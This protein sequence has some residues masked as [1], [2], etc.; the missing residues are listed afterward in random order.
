MSG[1]RKGNNESMR[2]YELWL[3]RIKYRIENILIKFCNEFFHQ[4][5]ISIEIE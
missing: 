3:Q 4:W 5:K 1:K 2:E